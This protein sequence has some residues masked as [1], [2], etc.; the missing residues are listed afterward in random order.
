MP[1][2]S[3]DGPA[4]YPTSFDPLAT[5]ESRLLPTFTIKEIYPMVMMEQ[6]E[7]LDRAKEGWDAYGQALAAAIPDLD[8][9]YGELEPKWTSDA[10]T[11]YYALVDN[12]KKSLVDWQDAAR[13]NS[14]A[15][16]ALADEITR[17]QGVMRQLWTDFTKG[18]AHAQAQEDSSD[19][20]WHA[21]LWRD[22]GEWGGTKTRLDPVVEDFTNKTIDKVLNPLNQAYKDAFV[23]SYPGSMF[24]GPTNAQSPTEQQW[25]D[26]LGG[27]GPG[28]PY[29]GAVPRPPGAPS[30]P[31]A[32]HPPRSGW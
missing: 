18:I 16:Q 20:P 2:P 23:A 19:A 11:L 12:T 17:L 15:L 22:I 30:R 1:D 25:R 7:T 24:Y 9:H 31:A 13:R 3:D 21:E 5:R 6:P 8:K 27:P 4:A 26:A 10:A 29:A 14:A 32:P 28:R